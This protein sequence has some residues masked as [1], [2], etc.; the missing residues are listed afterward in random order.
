M[1]DKNQKKGLINNIG[2]GLKAAKDIIKESASRARYRLVDIEKDEFDNYTATIQVINKS[3][4][5]KMKPEEILESDEM[6][7]CF[8]PIDIRTLTYLGYLGIN[9]PKYKILAKR[10]SEDDSRMQ[11]AIHKKGTNKV[12][13]KTA[14]EISGDKEILQS[15]DQKDAHAVGFTTAEEKS[16]VE[17]Q[18]QESLIK[19]FKKKS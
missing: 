1:S 2:K 7:L 16:A 6:T 12:E 5:F 14:A 8:S 11:F 3:Q 10:L 17:K 15:L 19:Q 13:V 18:Q 4:T 9:A